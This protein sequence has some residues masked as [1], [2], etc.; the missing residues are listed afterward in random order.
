[1]KA[2]IDNRIKV[3]DN[4]VKMRQFWFEF[5]G[6]KRTKIFICLNFEQRSIKIVQRAKK[7]CLVGLIW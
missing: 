1:M 4:S 5:D 2:K 3:V 6:K 7:S